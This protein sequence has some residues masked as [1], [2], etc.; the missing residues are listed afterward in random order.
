MLERLFS[1]LGNTA[2]DDGSSSPLKKL[3]SSKRPHPGMPLARQGDLPAGLRL[4]GENGRDGK[5]GSIVLDG[6]PVAWRE[7][8]WGEFTSGSRQWH[9]VRW[10]FFENGHVCFDALMSNSSEGIHLG[11]LQGHRIELREKGGLLLGVWAAGFFV[12]RGQ[13]KLGF[14]ADTI[15]DHPTLKM[16]FADLADEQAGFW[17]W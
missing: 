4:H 17:V 10:R 2:G 8:I 6:S 13:A 15:D 7:F 3:F 16:H 12:P 9:S 5:N 14:Q 1:W 11:H